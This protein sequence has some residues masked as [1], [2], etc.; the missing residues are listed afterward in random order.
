M[1]AWKRRHNQGI[2]CHESENMSRPPRPWRP[3]PY[4]NTNYLHGH[5]SRFSGRNYATNWRRVDGGG[6]HRQEGTMGTHPPKF[7]NC[8]KPNGMILSFEKRFCWEVGR[9]SWKRFVHAKRHIYLYDKVM[10]WNDSAVKDAFFEAKARF[11]AE[12]RGCPE[13]IP[14]PIP[15]IYVDSVDWNSGIETEDLDDQLSSI[16]DM[17]AD[18]HEVDRRKKIFPASFYIPLE[19]IK[20]TGWDEY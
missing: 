8:R 10:Q 9:M 1:S 13:H 4:D 5:Q 17:V 16:S 19:Q 12:L 3:K 6:R 15:D 20:A 2:Y 14:L 7:H 18:A 11:S